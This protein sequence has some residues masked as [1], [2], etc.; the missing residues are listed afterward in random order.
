M[1]NLAHPVDNQPWPQERYYR[2]APLWSPSGVVGSAAATTSTTGALA[3]SFSVAGSAITVSMALGRARVMGMLYER[4]DTP[5]IS[6]MAG[7]QPYDGSAVYPLNTNSQPRID[8]LVL[9][10]DLNIGK[11]YPLILQGTPAASP[12]PPALSVSEAGAFDLPLFRWQLAGASSTSVSNIVD[13][14][15]WIDPLS[16]REVPL[17]RL[18]GVLAIS[19]VEPGWT[20]GFS[21]V[22]KVGSKATL[23]ISVTRATGATTITVPANG[24]IGNILVATVAGGYEPIETVV[25]GTGTTGRVAAGYLASNG[26]INISSVAPGADI[27]VGTAFSLSV[28]LYQ[29]ATP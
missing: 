27:T 22:R 17:P 5:W 23:Y 7:D 18:D 16:G 19:S 4:T 13:E 20:L 2:D 24:D 28:P 15:L 9:R 3:L 8:R 10:R 21:F 26:Q 12:A 1:P 6:G 14:R 25:L 11:C 29:L